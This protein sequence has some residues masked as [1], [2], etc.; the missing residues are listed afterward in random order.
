MQLPDGFHY[1]NLEDESR[2]EDSQ[3][4]SEDELVARLQETR[5]FGSEKEVITCGY[6]GAKRRCRTGKCAESDAIEW[7][8]FHDC[9]T[10]SE[11]ASVRFAA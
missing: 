3:T 1:V 10:L 4:W 2:R 9:K 6:C 8:R 7:F 5:R 11:Q